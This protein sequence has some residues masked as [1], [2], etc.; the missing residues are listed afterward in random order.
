MLVVGAFDD[1]GNATIRIRI[2]GPLAIQSYIAIIDTGFSGFIAMPQVEMVPLGLAT[3]YA[4]AAVM[5]GNGEIIYNLVALGHV[6]IG[7]RTVAGPILL[8]ETTNDVLVGMAF[9]RAFKLALILTDTAVV[10][11]DK[12]ETWE[13][14][15]QFM[16]TAPAGLPNAS[17]AT[18]TSRGADNE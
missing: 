16:Q 9:L 11:H 10:L 4:A 13:A 5:L 14:V 15:A 17:P 6:T 18:S 2:G 8:D 7:G 3:Q 12:E 1:A